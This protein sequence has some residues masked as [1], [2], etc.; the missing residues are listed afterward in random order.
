MKG[1][2]LHLL[3]QRPGQTGSGVILDSLLRQAAGAGWEQCAAVGLPAG[4]ATPAVGGLDPDRIR[5]LYF[6]TQE[7]PFPLPGM[8]DVMPYPSSRFSAL[9]ATQID[10]YRRAW[11]KHLRELLAEFRPRLIHSHHVWLLSGL[12]K[13][14]APGL[15]VLT[16][17][18][19]TGL[20]QMALCPHLA[21]AVKRDC[22]RNDHFLTL[23]AEHGHKLAAALR[24][25]GT[26][27]T[28][29]G[30]AYREDLFHARRREA[31]SGDTLLFVGKFSRAKGLPQLLDACE[32]LASERPALRLHVVGGGGGEESAALTARMRAMSPRVIIHGVLEQSD[33]AALMRKCSVCALP[34]FFEGLP[35]VLVE[36]AACGCRLV[37]TNLPGIVSELKP[38]LGDGLH[39]V[40]TPALRRVDE[41]E[42]AGLPDFVASLSASL[43]AA[44]EGGP[45]P[46]TPER[47]AERCR[48]FAWS[49]VFGRVESVWLDLIEGSELS[50]S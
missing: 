45:L 36:A 14:L 38:V 17:C 42:A 16:S 6:E 23:H 24:L 44:L 49:T 35:L 50:S 28:R 46:E 33:L 19:A 12:V 34:S 4:M 40:S 18:H 11:R 22:A 1:P 2:V 41:P 27:I 26:R 31:T 9:N 48:P 30:G 43:A 7:L 21:E 37:A 5:P 13:D 47:L 32:I 8:S 25:P 3:S 15:P 39:L 20:R 29:M 10:D